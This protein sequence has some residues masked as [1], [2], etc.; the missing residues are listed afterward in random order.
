[1]R[2][3]IERFEK[4]VEDAECLEVLHNNSTALQIYALHKQALIGDNNSKRPGFR[5][6]ME[7]ARHD[8]WKRLKGT[9]NYQA[10]QSYI[11]LVESLR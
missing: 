10:I 4:A 8:A 7:R 3:L 11:D 5:K 9:T 6:T 1:M 2:E